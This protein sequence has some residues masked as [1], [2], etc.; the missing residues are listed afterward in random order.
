MNTKYIASK[1]VIVLIL[2]FCLTNVKGQILDVPYRRDLTGC[3]YW[4]WAMS[5]QM[6]IVYYGNDIQ[7]CDV[8]EVARQQNPSRFGYVNCCENPFG[9][10]C[11]TNYI[12][13]N[14]N[15]LNNWSISNVL[16][17]RSL[18]LNEIQSDLQSNRP[19]L[20][21]LFNS[22]GTGGH[23]VVGY[24]LDD[25]DVFIQNP[26]HGSQIRDYDDLIQSTIQGWKYSDRMNISAS[27]CILTQNIVGT[28][29]EANSIYKAKNLINASCKIKSNSNIKFQCENNVI[30][31]EE[32]EIELGSS[33]FI[34]TGINLICP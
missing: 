7:L 21:H 16:L 14:V 8:L 25:N 33:I 3:G 9:D 30:L 6:V 4:C 26:G 27:A 17:Y 19:F 12:S 31:K 23:T 24:G 1:L 22:D 18:T 13:A 28:I 2:S 11:N 34:E 15:I 32:F 29:N 20:M 5:C 10:C